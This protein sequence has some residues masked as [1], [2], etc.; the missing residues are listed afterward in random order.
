MGTDKHHGRV[1][2]GRSGDSGKTWSDPVV[3]LHGQWHTAPVPVIGYAG[4]IWKA[5][6]DAHTGDKWGERYR[7]RMLS[8]PAA[9]DLPDPASWTV[10]EALGRD[11]GWLEGD[12]AAWLE[13]NAVVA[14]DGGIVNVLRVDTSRQPERA[15]VL[16]VSEDGRTAGFDPR[17]DLVEM[18]GGAKKFTIRKDP[19]GPGYWTLATIVPERH[20]DDGRPASVRNTLAL[21]HSADLR[22]W[23]LRCILLYHPDVVPHG[24]QYVDWQFDG[25][26]LIAVCRTAWDDAEGGARNHHDANF[27]T[28]HRWPG[29][30]SM[31]RADDVAMPEFTGTALDTHALTILGGSCEIAVLENG[32]KAFSNRGYRWQGIPAGLAGRSFTRLA[33]WAKDLRKVTAKLDTVV[34]IATATGQ[35][36]IDLPGWTDEGLEFSYDDAG[37]TKVRVYSRPLK[38]GES[39]RLP[40]GNWTGAIL[41]LETDGSLQAVFTLSHSAVH[42]GSWSP[43]SPIGSHLAKSSSGGNRTAL[44]RKS[45]LRWL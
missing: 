11:P 38:A 15:A 9:A 6:E 35:A 14:P 44:P 28:F 23:E 30:R 24:F 22:K 7:A 8:A 34:R 40:G 43:R 39:L 10:S 16:R 2:I 41:I 13:G 32:A 4:R 26:D 36:G 42:S 21:L 19:G 27:L 18:P 31:D 5:L 25:E 45:S 29:F 33:G 3:L 1:V 12:F 17:S 37:N 20:R